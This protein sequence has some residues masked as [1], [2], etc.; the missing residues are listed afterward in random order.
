V[1]KNILRICIVFV[2]FFAINNINLFAKEADIEEKVVDFNIQME[3]NEDSSVD[4]EESFTI[5]ATEHMKE[6]VVKRSFPVEYDGRKIEITNIEASENGENID[7]KIN[8][9]DRNIVINLTNKELSVKKYTYNIK[10]KVSNLIKFKKD[11]CNINW[12]LFS[13]SFGIP[14]NN[15]TIK[16]KFPSGTKIDKDYFEIST[17]SN[18][19][20][21]EKVNLPVKIDKEYIEYSD[22]S[23]VY[24]GTDIILEVSFENNKISRPSFIK[25][26]SNFFS[27]N[28][29]SIVV[30]ILSI[31]AFIFQLYILKNSVKLEKNDITLRILIMLASNIFI[32]IISILIGMNADYDITM[33]YMK[34]VFIKFMSLLIFEG[35]ITVITYLSVRYELFEKSKL[36]QIASILV[37]VPLICIG[38]IFLS[39]FLVDIYY[40]IFG[41]LVLI[42]V[43]ISDM[44]YAYCLKEKNCNIE[45]L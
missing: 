5:V 23:L 22:D 4:V 37:V 43:L 11:S 15:Y 6:Y 38:M 21:I 16:I 44:Y 25:I 29:I 19:S 7:L 32:F 36:N 9:K 24:P 18:E 14:I 33:N 12:N 17:L 2:M 34:N 26:I 8:R 27:R 40:N 1:N 10:Y 42:F 28:L 30:F 39:N 20:K 35:F 13:D 3:I 45:I 31:I 41:Y